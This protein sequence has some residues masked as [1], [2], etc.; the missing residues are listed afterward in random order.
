MLSCLLFK[1]FG[2][3]SNSAFRLTGVFGG[4]FDP[5][6]YGH[7]RVAEEI[8][9]M[10]GLQEM[11]FIPARRPRLREAP[12]APYCHR[13]AMVHI[14]IECNPAFILDG[15]ET[16][17]SGVSYSVETLRELKRELGADAILCFIVGADAFTRFAQWH[18]WLEIF[19]LCHLIIVRRPGVELNM[20]RDNLPPELWEACAQ[21]W[22][23]NPDDL[24]KARSGLIFPAP[25]IL[26]DISAT[27]IRVRLAAG[28]SVRYLLPDA[29]LDYISAHHLYVDK[30]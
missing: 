20:N 30:V 3:M 27:A 8:A 29:T 28:K 18:D 12:V 11:R 17:S 21:R 26:L 22:V 13:E 19:D 24:R 5:I 4:T 9:E 23:A 6:H 10:I 25:T 16:R 14:A 15:R 7:L 1:L 2:L